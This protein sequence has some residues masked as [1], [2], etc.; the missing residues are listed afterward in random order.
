M[1]NLKVENYVLFTALTEDYSLV[2]SL[3]D[4]PEGLSQRGKG[5]ARIQ[6]FLLKKM[7]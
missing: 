6:E 5:G 2:H 4:H 3:S 7:K 1:H